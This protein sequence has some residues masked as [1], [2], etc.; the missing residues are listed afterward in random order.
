MTAEILV[1]RIVHILG[2]AFWVGSAIV[3]TVFLVPALGTLG[4]TAGQVFGA[5]QKRHLMNTVFASALLS[6]LAGMR[7]LWITS[8][9]MSSA[10]MATPMGRTFAWS[11]ALALVALLIGAL[12][13][14]PSGMRMGRIGA[15]LATASAD[16]RPALMAEMQRLRQRNAVASTTVTVLIVITTIGMAVARYVR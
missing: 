5:L 4:P 12:V 13:S 7:L 10:Y 15:Q 1:L 2:G 11:G 9:G 8:G 3:S 16:D 6:V 14:R